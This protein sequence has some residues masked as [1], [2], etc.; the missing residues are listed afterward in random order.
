MNNNNNINI[1]NPEIINNNTETNNTI[2]VY[3][4]KKLQRQTSPK[5]AKDNIETLNNNSN[6]SNSN[7]KNKSEEKKEDIETNK[8]ENKIN[9]TEEKINP[10]FNLYK[11]IKEGLLTFNL[12]KKNYYTIVPENYSEFWEQFDPET[13]IQYN[14]LEGLFLVNSK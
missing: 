4:K 6:K 10:N 3:N 8:E 9:E 11:P 13:S 12:S 14:T 5:S 1:N 2:K 7:I